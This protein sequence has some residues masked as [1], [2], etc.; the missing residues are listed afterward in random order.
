MAHQAEPKPFRIWQLVW[1]P[2]SIIGDCESK[3]RTI[4]GKANINIFRSSMFGGVRDRLLSNAVELCGN[5]GIA[6]WN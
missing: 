6:D 4:H 3:L 1:D 5:C 2:N